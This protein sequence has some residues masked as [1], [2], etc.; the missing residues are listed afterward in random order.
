MRDEKGRFVKGSTERFGA[1]L[2]DITKKKI[3][4]TLKKRTGSKA[5]RWDGGRIINYT[6]YALIRKTNHPFCKFGY[7]YEHRLIMEETLGRYLLPK[8]QVH[9]INGDKTDNR[10][11]NLMLFDNASK[12]TKYHADLAIV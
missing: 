2:T 10:I 3:S 8:E 6:G 1:K 12:H 11:E 7:V 5:S 4:E 9:H